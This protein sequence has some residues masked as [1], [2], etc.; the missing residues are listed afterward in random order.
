MFATAFKDTKIISTL[1]S[2]IFNKLPKLLE[3]L[4]NTENLGNLDEKIA[5]SHYSMHKKNCGGGLTK[6]Q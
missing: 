4:P 1:F 6:W 5:R 3:K 2:K